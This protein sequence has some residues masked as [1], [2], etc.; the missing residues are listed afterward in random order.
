MEKEEFFGSMLKYFNLSEVEA[1]KMLEENYKNP[2]DRWKL[3]TLLEATLPYFD[4]YIDQA[5][6]KLK[7]KVGKLFME[8]LDCSKFYEKESNSQL[9]ERLSWLFSQTTAKNINT[10]KILY[11]SVLT[12]GNLKRD[13]DTRQKYY[14]NSRD[15]DSIYESLKTTLN[16]SDEETVE[17]FER[18]SS[19]I[20]K[21]YDFKFPEIYNTLSKLFVS[22]DN[23]PVSYYLFRKE[24]VSQCLLINLSLFLLTPERI[25][26]A[27]IYVKQKMQTKWREE[28]KSVIER[29]P[30]MTILDYKTI[31]ARKCFKNN[32]SLFSLNSS[33]MKE[34]EN[35]LRDI[36]SLTD[37]VYSSQINQL[38]ETPVNLSI[39]NSIPVDKISKYGL[40]NI[41]KLESIVSDKS[42]IGRYILKNQYVIG[43]NNSKF[44]DLIDEVSRLEEICPQENYLE[45]FLEL[46]KTLFASNI[47]FKVASIVEKLKN[48]SVII[49]IDVDSLSDRECLHQFVE[50]FFDGNHEIARDIEELIKDKQ[51][52]NSLG[53]KEV[54]KKIRTIGRQIEEF[55]KMIKDEKLSLR[56]KKLEILKVAS[57]V[58]VLH[59]ARFALLGN[60]QNWF[61]KDVERKYSDDIEKRLN[62][63]R[64]VYEQKRFK[65]G[66]RY[67]NV[68]ELFDRTMEYLSICFDDKE[69]I[70]DLFRENVLE[71]FNEAM[72]KTFDN[73][74]EYGQPQFTRNNNEMQIITKE[75]VVVRDVPD[76][77]RRPLQNL[78]DAINCREDGDEDGARIVDFEKQK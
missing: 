43:M 51:R 7:R 38:F 62:L 74:V 71:V 33:K 34:K 46:G 23:F 53:E 32:L 76:N 60:E 10:Y 73:T 31:Q 11:C 29:N 58:S 55:P 68:D 45:K 35:A 2:K 47:D 15:F 41:R 48:N 66:K 49:D 44:S 19:L 61:L 17:C 5:D 77:L 18:C 20:A 4:P 1:G 9:K 59:E 28:S 50:M 30:N 56:K 8:K 42:K 21:G 22:E 16:L 37:R 57:D 27:F 64:E 40:K 72:I 12:D 69:P 13:N 70:T 67:S 75:V 24:E 78:N 6:E 39:V 25:Q 65:L 36:N 63:L 54:R 14:D 3:V 52:R 26:D